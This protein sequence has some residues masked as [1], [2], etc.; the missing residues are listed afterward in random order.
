MRSASRVQVWGRRTLIAASSVFLF[1][2]AIVQVEQRVE[3]RRAERL[4]EDIRSLQLN[5]STWNE[6]QKVMM[7]WGAWGHYDGMCDT[8]SCEYDIDLYPYPNAPNSFYQILRYGGFVVDRLARLLVFGN[9]ASVS[10][11]IGVHHGLVDQLRFNVTTR[12]PKGDGPGWDGDGPEP[13][14]YVEYKTGEYALIATARSVQ[15]PRSHAYWPKAETHPEYGMWQPDGCEICIGF[16]TDFTAATRQKDLNWLMGFDLSCMTR[17]SPCTT[18]ADLM[19]AAWSRY[20]AE[21]KVWRADGDQLDRCDFRLDDLAKAAEN[22]ALFSVATAEKLAVPKN[23]DPP[24]NVQLLS[25]L[26]G[27]EAINKHEVR[28]IYDLGFV[29]NHMAS[30]IP[31]GTELIVLYPE[32]TSDS[33]DVQQLRPYRCGVIAANASNVRGVT[34]AIP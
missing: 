17:W 3:R 21:R 12:V 24:L 7:R 20:V 11:G 18:E 27:A 10:A 31:V 6:A 14:G 16:H 4:L 1:L 13:P 28:R 33:D 29:L 23:I 19:P 8:G 30:D 5:K 34:S 2:F 22:I 26:K 25:M 9:M 15:K 32:G